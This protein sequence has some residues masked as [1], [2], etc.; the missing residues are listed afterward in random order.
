MS[1]SNLLNISRYSLGVYQKAMEVTSHNI[2]NANNPNFSRQQVVLSTAP[3]SHRV[4]GEYGSGVKLEDVIRIK[5]SLTELQIRTYNQKYGDLNKRSEVLEQVESVFAEPTDLGLSNLM[6]TFFNSWDEVATTPTS[7]PLR[8]KVVEN[9][10]KLAVQV[11]NI[12]DGL[13]NSKADVLA[14]TNRVIKEVNQHLSDIQSLNQQVSEAKLNGVSA[15]DLLDQRD[16]KINELSLLTNINVTTNDNDIVSISIGGVFAVDQY[17]SAQFS[18]DIVDN[19]LIVTDG[20]NNLALNGGELFAL[21]DLYSKDITD[22][23][24]R[25]DNIAQQLVTSVN[26]IHSTGFTNHSTPQTGINFFTS[27]SAGKLE[28]NSQ[29]LDD[30]NYVAISGNGQSGNGEIALQLADLAKTKVIN[31]QSIGDYYNAFVSEVGMNKQINDQGMESNKLV[32]DQLEVQKASYSGVSLDE[33][34]TNVIKF[35]RAYDASARL[36]RVADEML[37]SLLNMMS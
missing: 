23:L 5:N 14:E 25:I 1:I 15:N 21:T 6:N 7:V 32:I 36:V 12:Y 24:N 19:K 28:I 11:Q 22:Y 16:R 20:N 34:M 27:Y 29:L 31:N 30:P 17:Y 2:S 9:A 10:K 4:E 26:A 35:Q 3:T 8:S 13:T 37:Q 33:E 18:S